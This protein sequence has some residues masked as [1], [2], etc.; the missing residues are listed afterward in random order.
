MANPKKNPNIGDIL[1]EI[2]EPVKQDYS[3]K[4][5]SNL[6]DTLNEVCKQ[7]D[8]NDWVAVTYDSKWYPGVIIEEC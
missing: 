4:Y 8:K 2:F 1:E 7:W 5:Q 3:E 6:K